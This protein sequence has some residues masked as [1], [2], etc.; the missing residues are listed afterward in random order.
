VTR[1]RKQGEESLPGDLLRNRT[2]LPRIPLIASRRMYDPLSIPPQK[3]GVNAGAG[4]AKKI[5]NL[6]FSG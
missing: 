5:T 3:S 6:E 4:T 1:A 2:G